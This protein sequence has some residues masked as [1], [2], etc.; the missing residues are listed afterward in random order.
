[1]RNKKFYKLVKE[2]GQART[3]IINTLNG[4]IK[5]PTFM[6]VGTLGTVKALTPK[7]LESAGSDIIL[8]NTYHLM[9]QPGIDVI[10]ILGG[11]HKFMNWKRPILTDSGGFQVWS[12]SKLAKINEKGI[13]FQSHLDGKK[14]FLTPE[15]AIELQTKFGSDIIMV[16]D[17]CTHYPVSKSKAKKSMEL[18]MRWAERSIQS[19]DKKE[20]R[21]IFGIVQGGMYIDLRK[22]S[23]KKLNTL[24]FDGY[25]IGGLS[26][27]EPHKIMLNIVKNTVKYL[28]KD[29]PR[30]LM[31]VGR[32]EDILGAV[33]LGI[34]MFDC[35]IPTRFGR[36]G[37]AFS[38]QGEINLRNSRHAKDPRPLERGWNS[39]IK[40]FSRAYLHHLIKTNEMLGSILLSWHNIKFYL[41]LMENIQS[42]IS[43]KQFSSFKK[44]FLAK[45]KKG[46]IPSI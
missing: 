14:H 15:D 30:Y 45:Y 36:N 41:E 31:G 7:M 34:D 17:E 13:T 42:A 4:S 32:P 37:R 25:A 44:K 29:K 11:L 40:N 2:S 8:A 27:G 1:M 16:L 26:V 33:E 20:G 35:V 10:K 38:L 5:T 23:A 21:G 39:P 43:K 28:P 24:D 12:L 22:Q 46:D 6:P 3:G 19:Y 9:L 18:S